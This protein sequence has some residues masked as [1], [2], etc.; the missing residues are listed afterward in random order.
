MTDDTP[1]ACSLNASQLEQRLAE[2]AAVGS[3]SLISH[4]REGDRHLLRFRDDATT[5]QRLEAIAAA[6]AECCS[7]LELLLSEDAGELVLSIGAPEE[8]EA[9]AAELAAA[10]IDENQ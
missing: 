1:I 9:V 6:E 2:I 3:A 5:R 8:A 7:F 4:T 10:F